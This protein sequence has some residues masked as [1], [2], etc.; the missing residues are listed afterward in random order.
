MAFPA[1]APSATSSSIDTSH[2]F[3]QIL[4]SNSGVLDFTMI[5]KQLN[6]KTEK[7]ISDKSIWATIIDADKNWNRMQQENLWIKG[8]EAFLCHTDITTENSKYFDLLDSLH[9]GGSFQLH[10]LNFMLWLPLLIVLQ[11]MS[12]AQ[13]FKKM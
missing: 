12:W 10:V 2:Q 4:Y 13:L 11:I 5:P 8:I 9:C 1:S 7:Y 3:P 6:I